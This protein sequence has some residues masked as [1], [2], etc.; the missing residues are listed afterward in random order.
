MVCCKSP[1]N[2]PAAF[3][4]ALLEMKNATACAISIKFK[5]NFFLLYKL[6]AQTTEDKIQDILWDDLDGGKIPGVYEKIS[7]YCATNAK[8]FEVKQVAVIEI[9]AEG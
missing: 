6:S 3:S 4:K 7:T 1:K 2:I 5:G 8:E 9:N